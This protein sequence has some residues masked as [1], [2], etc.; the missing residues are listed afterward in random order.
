MITRSSQKII[1][2]QAQK[3]LFKKIYIF[4]FGPLVYVLYIN[5]NMNYNVQILK[6]KQTKKNKK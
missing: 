3:N 1:C 6:E 5:Y 2:S 4:V